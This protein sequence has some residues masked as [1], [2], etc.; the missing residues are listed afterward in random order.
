MATD[1][2]FSD[3]QQTFA[4]Y[5][6]EKN[7]PNSFNTP[8]KS[9]LTYKQMT[10]KYKK[11]LNK[12]QNETIKKYLGKLDF[13]TY[14][15]PTLRVT[16]R[17]NYNNEPEYIMS[18]VKDGIQHTLTD[19]NDVVLTFGPDD[20]NAMPESDL[21]KSNKSLNKIKLDLLNE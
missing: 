10:D 9:E 6:P 2:F 7:Y 12:K 8:E 16:S 14:Q 17:L 1:R 3:G 5:P 20:F 21:P 13:G 18:Y 19:D 4:K 15:N 11:F